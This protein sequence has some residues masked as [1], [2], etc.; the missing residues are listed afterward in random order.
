MLARG[1]IPMTKAVQEEL[2]AVTEA[3]EWVA[4][5]NN[6]RIDRYHR[7]DGRWY[8]HFDVSPASGDSLDIGKVC[9]GPAL[10]DIYTDARDAAD[11]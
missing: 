4:R 1:R 2:S 9:D 3:A 6:W 5:S 11:E 8:V 7:E 10:V